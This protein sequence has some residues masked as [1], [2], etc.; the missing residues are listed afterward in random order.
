MFDMFSPEYIIN[1]ALGLIPTWVPWAISGFGFALFVLVHIFNKLIPLLYR[2]VITVVCFAIFG[3]GFWL[4]GRQNI[5]IE[6]QHEVEK[7]VE[8][9]VV[10]TKVVVQK[11]KEQVKKDEVIHDQIISQVNTKDDH[12]CD[13]PESFVR[14]HDSAAENSVPGSTTGIDGAS[15][16]IAL[17]EV[18]KTIIDNYYT[19]HIVADQLKALQE[20]VTK[21]K[22][23]NP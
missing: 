20:W 18:E 13:V 23:A 22:E 21:E 17:S 5:L 14:L 3:L 1:Y 19:Y 15:S 2:F 12:M 10:I 4:E 9:Q 11:F 16:G 6:G 7:I 8:K